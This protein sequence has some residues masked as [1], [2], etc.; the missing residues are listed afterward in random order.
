MGLCTLFYQ[1]VDYDGAAAF[2]PFGIGTWFYFA[3]INGHSG[4]VGTHT[5]TSMPCVLGVPF[6]TFPSGGRSSTPT[7]PR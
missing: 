1:P 5:G 3:G 7:G 6:T 2:L 4:T